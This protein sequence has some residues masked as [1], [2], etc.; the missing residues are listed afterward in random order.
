MARI[1]YGVMGD[2]RGHLSRS[3]SVAQ[4]MPGHEFLFAGGGTVSDVQ[5]EGYDFIPLE[6][7]ATKYKKSRVDFAATVG[8]AV[9]L[10]LTKKNAIVK[11]LVEI[12]RDFDP[13]LILSDYEFFTPL[14]ARCLG[15]PCISLDHQHV[16]TH[17]R[18]A[19]PSGQAFN[20]KITFFPILRLYSNAT[21]FLVSSFYQPPPKNPEN[22][23][24]FPPILRKVVK[25]HRPRDDEHVLVYTSGGAYSD[26]LPL[27]QGHNRKFIVY[28]FGERPATGNLVFKKNSVHGFLED[29][30]GAYYV[31]SNGGHSL[32]SEALYYGKPVLSFPIHFLYEQFLN[33]YFLKEYCY[34]R[35]SMNPDADKGILNEF[36]ESIPFFKK[37]IQERYFWGN[38]QVVRRIES[39]IQESRC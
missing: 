25:D 18:C 27:L 14:A 29:L 37:H 8:N 35:F 21:R 23:E 20:R 33:G 31:I 36:E 28:G 1:F 39:L 38:D 4:H 7:L 16:L 22:T 11:R 2:A 5:N 9:S 6:M 10:L 24:I 19:L 15:R 26:L 12:I 3:L 34:G 32:I 13:D 17:T 30:V